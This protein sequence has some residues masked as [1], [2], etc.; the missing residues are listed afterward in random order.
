[1]TDSTYFTVTTPATNG[2]AAINAETG[3]WTFT[4]SDANWFGSDSFTVTVTDD[5]GGTTTQVVNITLVNVDD[6]AVLPM[7]GFLLH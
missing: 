5:L 3:T 7:T 1:M 4:P 6:S 2:T